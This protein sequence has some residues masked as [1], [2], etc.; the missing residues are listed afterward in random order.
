MGGI[1]VAGVLA[2]SPN[3]GRGTTIAGGILTFSVMSLDQF[4]LMF[5]LSRY[6]KLKR[7]PSLDEV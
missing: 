3:T 4:S 6:S 7:M 5:V 2:P 1:V